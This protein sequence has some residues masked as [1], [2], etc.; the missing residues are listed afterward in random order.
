MS[1]ASKR[2]PGKLV[3]ST[4]N[5]RICPKCGAAIDRCSCRDVPTK[6]AGDGGARVGRST[7]GRRGKIVTFVEGLTLGDAALAELVRDLKK[8]CSSGGT[9]KSGVIEIQGDHRELILDE[10]RARGYKVR[11]L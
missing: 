4:Q 6:P 9:L 3:Y 5:G 2:E 7:K 1:P 10:L 11:R 8:K